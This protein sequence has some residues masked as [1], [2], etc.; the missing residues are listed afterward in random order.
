MALNRRERVRAAT[1]NEIKELAADQISKKGNAEISLRAIA[2]QMG[3]T[4]PALY[5]YFKSRDELITAIVIDSMYAMKKALEDARD[6]A[7]SDDIAGKIFEVFMAWRNWALANPIPYSLFSG[8]P[9]PGYKPP[10][11]KLNPISILVSK[12]VMDLYIEAWEQGKLSVPPEY[13]DLPKDYRH[14][15]E[16]LKKNRGYQLPI[17]VV[18]LSLYGWGLIHGLISLEAAERWKPLIE[19]PYQVFRFQVIVELKRFGLVPK[20]L[21]SHPET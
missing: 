19:D 1:I 2:K 13:K 14:Q 16:A 6:K 3:M 5:R 9:L 10:W 20:S 11:D 21:K 12:V 15:L 8:N 7:A 4:A 18:H 17:E